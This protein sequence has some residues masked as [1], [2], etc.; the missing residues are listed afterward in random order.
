MKISDLFR[1]LSFG[2]LSNLSIS[3]SGSGELD[4][5]QHPKMIHYTNDGL[6]ALY[7]R[8]ILREKEVIIEQKTG[9]TEYLI[10]L[11][12]TESQNE[13]GFDHYIKDAE[14]P[15]EDDLIKILEAWDYKGSKYFL[16]DVGQ[17]SSLFTPKHNM[18]QVP[19]PID[20][21]PISVV[22]QAR[23]PKLIDVPAEGLDLV[24]QEFDLPVILEKTLKQYI[25]YK[26]FSHMN[27]QENIIKGQE[28]L[29]AYEADC[30]LAEQRDLVN[31][32]IHT[33]HSKLEQRG[34][35]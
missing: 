29:G 24:D 26:V 8:F 7:S 1:Q 28:Y 4:I 20:E 27:G 12:H 22:Y 16:N 25:A 32:T 31:Q 10:D 6:L 18:L 13:S 21:E 30:S 9:V 23:A 33:S 5:K 15:F 14:D 17:A 11:N 2:E 3:N 34:F 35:I 19:M